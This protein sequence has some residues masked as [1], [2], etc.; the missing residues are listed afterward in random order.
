MWRSLKR[1]QTELDAYDNPLVQANEKEAHGNNLRR[2]QVD[3][4]L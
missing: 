4:Q 3:P 1:D 2:L